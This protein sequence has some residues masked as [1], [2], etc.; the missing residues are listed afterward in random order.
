[1]LSVSGPGLAPTSRWGELDVGS[2]QLDQLS[3]VEDDAQGRSVRVEVFAADHLCNAVARLYERHSELLPD[4]EAR[5]R[6]AATARAITAVFCGR[7][8]LDGVGAVLGPDVEFVD[9]RPL[10][11]PAPRGPGTHLRPPSPVVDLTDGMANR[12]D[13][14]LGLRSDGVV[15]RI[16][17]VGTERSGGGA[18]ER[19]IVLLAVLGADGLVS[20]WEFFAPDRDGEAMARFDELTAPSSPPSAARRRRVVRPNAAAM[21]AAALDAACASRAE[22]ALA[23]DALP[24]GDR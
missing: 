1:R 5:A 22:Q 7:I 4:G 8:T 3:L 6:A 2:Y 11:L 10:R 9:H 20:H 17:N 19:P 15:F 24:Y 23:P 21:N 18:F 14:V 12:I 13:D 16:M